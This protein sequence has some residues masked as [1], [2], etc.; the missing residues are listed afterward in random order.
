MKAGAGTVPATTSRKDILMART[1]SAS[2]LTLAI[3]AA[4]LAGCASTGTPAT[5]SDTAAPAA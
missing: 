4:F 5:T 1:S 3:A 2:T